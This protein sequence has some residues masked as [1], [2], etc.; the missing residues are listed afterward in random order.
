M[1]KLKGQVGIIGAGVMGRALAQ[2]LLLNKLVRP[3]QLWATT[4]S[5][6]S[7]REASRVLKIPVHTEGYGEQVRKSSLIILAVKPHQ[8]RSV[9]REL[10]KQGFRSDTTVLSLVTGISLA[11]LSA[12][13]PAKTP[14]I[15]AITNTPLRVGEGMTALVASKSASSTDLRRAHEIF[16]SVGKVIEIEESQCEAMTGLAASGP[17]YLYLIMEALADGGVKVGLSRQV[18]MAAV[19]QMVLGSARM[20][21]KS[22]SH[23]ASLRDEVT[24]P[25]GC[26]IAGLMILEDGKIRSTLARAVEEATETARRLGRQER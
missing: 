16:S 10:V 22:G 15:R 18:A 19:A 25:A 17:A 11:E 4:K 5:N 1:T 2:S 6:S 8:T 12:E 13:L 3:S 14:I 9:L 7:A 20:V 21:Q 26:T 24:T 23:P